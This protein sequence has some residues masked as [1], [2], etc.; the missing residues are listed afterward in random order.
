METLIIKATR[1]SPCMELNGRDCFLRI[2]GNSYPQNALQ[3]YQPLLE[4]LKSYF[5]GEK[6]ELQ[7]EFKLEYIS[8]S[9]QRFMRRILVYLFQMHQEGHKIC[10]NWLYPSGDEDWRELCEMLLEGLDF[11]H[12]LLEY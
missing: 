11:P 1:Y 3:L 2:Q 6:R 5:G 9:S 7:I 12:Y 10:L 4:A 8:S